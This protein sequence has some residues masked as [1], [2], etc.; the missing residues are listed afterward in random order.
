VFVWHW[1]TLTQINV[2]NTWITQQKESNSLISLFLFFVTKIVI[3]FFIVRNKFKI[4]DYYFW[5]KI[6]CLSTPLPPTFFHLL[7][8]PNC[9]QV[10]TIKTHLTS[11][12]STLQKYAH[13]TIFYKFLGSSVEYATN[14]IWKSRYFTFC[15]LTILYKSTFVGRWIY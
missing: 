3:Y 9:I 12:V 14:F 5:N 2:F 15:K 1:D 4:R 8:I 6:K 13:L 10:L 7:R 11:D